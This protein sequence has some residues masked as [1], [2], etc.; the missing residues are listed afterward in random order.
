MIL[1]EV[2]DVASGT[3]RTNPTVGIPQI[4]KKATMTD[5]PNISD[6]D[7]TLGKHAA[8]LGELII[9]RE[10]ELSHTVG[11]PRML[12]ELDEMIALRKRLQRRML[13]GDGEEFVPRP[14]KRSRLRVVK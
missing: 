11:D 2:P 12:A 8:D 13:N 1:S 6:I 3:T 10:R 9:Q 5:K 7:K 14:P 4:E